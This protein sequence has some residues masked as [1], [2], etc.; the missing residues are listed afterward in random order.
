M[1]PEEQKDLTEEMKMVLTLVDYLDLK[2][3]A[4]GGPHTNAPI[5]SSIFDRTAVEYHY[6]ITPDPPGP[7]D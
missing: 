2:I 1:I 5:D 7:P 3:R 6:V 4:T